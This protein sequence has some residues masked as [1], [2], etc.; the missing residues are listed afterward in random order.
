M[1]RLLSVVGCVLFGGCVLVVVGVRL[2]GCCL[3]FVVVCVG[4]WLCVACCFLV[5][6]KCML[7]AAC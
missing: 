3:L 4:V 7:F 6:V 2:N 1:C 5:A